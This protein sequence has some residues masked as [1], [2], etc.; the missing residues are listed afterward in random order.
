MLAFFKRTRQSLNFP[1]QALKGVLVWCLFAVFALEAFADEP[2]SDGPKK[3]GPFAV[4]L[5]KPATKYWLYVP[6]EYA[7]NRSS[8]MIV[9]LHGAGDTAENI[10]KAYVAEAETNRFIICTVKS[11]GEAWDD[12]DGDLILA[13]M[14]DVAKKYRIDPERTFLCGYSSGG[15]MTSRFG[16]KNHARFRGI[17]MIAGARIEGGGKAFK[18]AA[19]HMCALIVCG[20]KDPNMQVCEESYNRL[21]K[22]RFDVEF[23]KVEGMEHSPLKLEV[24]PW[25]LKKFVE[26]ITGPDALLVRGRKA[27]AQKRYVDALD[28]FNQIVWVK[29][30]E[31]Y[32]KAAAAE[33]AKIEKVAKEKLN[34][35]LKKAE[36]DKKA[37]IAALKEVRDTFEGIEP[38]VQAREKLKELEPAADPE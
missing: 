24:I 17:A 33:I 16:M 14:D 37:G 3:G 22:N 29:M 30:G 36:K 19:A 13:V 28:A 2:T 12:S 18:E 35:A 31:K 11:R 4:E 25:V 8:P 15:F 32:E 9:G 10:I 38:A 6:D 21:V 5:A 34:A 20:T 27:A 7:P 26:R 1:S 23:N